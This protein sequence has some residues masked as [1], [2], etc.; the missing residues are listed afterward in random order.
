[1]ECV[2]HACRHDDD[3]DAGENAVVV[4]D[5]TMAVANVADTNEIFISVLIS[6]AVNTGHCH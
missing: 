1:M 6:I 3:D 2:L 4:G 5:A